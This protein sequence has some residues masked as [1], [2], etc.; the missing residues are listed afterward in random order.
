M[1]RTANLIYF[2]DIRTLRRRLKEPKKP[3]YRGMSLQFVVQANIAGQLSLSFHVFDVLPV[4]IS[5]HVFHRN[6]SQGGRIDAIALTAGGYRAVVK[7]MSQMRI[8]VS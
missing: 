1:S 8:A 4:S 7:L 6:E 2:F 3:E 5:L